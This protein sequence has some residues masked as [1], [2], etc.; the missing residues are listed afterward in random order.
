[1]YDVYLNYFHQALFEEKGNAVCSALSVHLAL[2]M[3]HNGAKGETA[4]KLNK[5][6]C[7]STDLE[8]TN[9]GFKKLVSKLHVC[10]YIIFGDHSIYST[11]KFQNLISLHY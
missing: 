4:E 11:I 7:L 3:L 9:Q 5:A 10:I 2:A 1:M 6:L 8:S